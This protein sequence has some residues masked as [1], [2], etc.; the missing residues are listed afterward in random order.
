MKQQTNDLFS[1]HE[2][3]RKLER[4]LNRLWPELKQKIFLFAVQKILTCLLASAVTVNLL[5]H[6]VE[7]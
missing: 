5:F 6:R 1:F 2:L 3:T 4:L 7:I